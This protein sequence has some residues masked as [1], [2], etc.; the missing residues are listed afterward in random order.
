MRSE[1]AVNVL[2]QPSAG[3]ASEC[4]LNQINMSGCKESLFFCN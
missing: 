2:T 4:L 1:D 3:V